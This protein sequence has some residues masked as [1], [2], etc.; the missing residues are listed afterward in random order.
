MTADNN[1]AK[2]DNLQHFTAVSF[3]N[4]KKEGVEKF[5]PSQMDSKGNF[6]N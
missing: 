3:S 1:V 6:S 4:G 2:H 5:P